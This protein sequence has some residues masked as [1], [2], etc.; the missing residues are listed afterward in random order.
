MRPRC[1]AFGGD[2]GVA[3]E[4]GAGHEAADSGGEC[5]CSGPRCHASS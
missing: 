4:A 2:C 1:A 3:E 5:G